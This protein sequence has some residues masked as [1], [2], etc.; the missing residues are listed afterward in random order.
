MNKTETTDIIIAG[1]GIVGAAAALLL[2]NRNFKVRLLDSKSP[3]LEKPVE[4]SA[5]VSSINRQSEKVLRSIGFEF[6]EFSTP[7]KELRVR[8]VPAKQN[9]DFTARSIAKT[10][11]ATIVDNAFLLKC[12]WQTINSHK[13]IIVNVPAVVTDLN[14]DAAVH[15]GCGVETF[16]ANLLLAADGANSK[17]RNLLKI[18]CSPKPYK[19][20]AL[21]AVIKTTLPHKNIGRQ[22]FAAD[23]PLAFLPID[24]NNMQAIVFSHANAAQW[25]QQ[26]NTAELEQVLTDYSQSAMGK[27]EVCGKLLAFPLL[28]RHAQSYV[29]NKVGLLGDAA[30]T[31]HPL[32]GQGANLGIMDAAAIADV[33]QAARD[34]NSDFSSLVVLKQ[35]QR[36]RR[37]DNLLMQ[38]MMGFLRASTAHDDKLTATLRSIALQ[39]LNRTACIKKMLMRLA[40]S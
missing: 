23:G 14:I 18:E 12:L 2:A 8:D 3:D 33:L 22:W 36:L 35:Y 31:I 9:L 20:D 16:S 37:A 26:Q 29:A 40:G 1:G 13:N 34:N 38:Q 17:V 21:V 32:A 11:L 27:V 5:W 15:V 28:A 6:N 7:I 19:H 30:H 25:L 24:D 10:H 39:G 4:P